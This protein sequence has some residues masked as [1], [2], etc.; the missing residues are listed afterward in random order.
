MEYLGIIS[1]EEDI[2]GKW[3]VRVD[4]GNNESATLK[5]QS[6]PSD[7]EI[8]TVALRYI[9]NYNISSSKVEI[10]PYSGLNTEQRIAKKVSDRLTEVGYTSELIAAISLNQLESPPRH[11]EEFAQ[12]NYLRK[13]FSVQVYQEEGMEMPE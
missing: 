11:P 6:N 8:E 1:K 3:R 10:D 7:S 12:L 13:M 4:L 5:F 9:S 2:A